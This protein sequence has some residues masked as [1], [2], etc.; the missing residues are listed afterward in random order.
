MHLPY[1]LLYCWL[2]LLV[3]TG[4][5]GPAAGQPQPAPTTT[6]YSCTPC[7]ALCDTLRQVGPGTCRY[8][9]MPLVARLKDARK[10]KPQHL[11]RRSLRGIMPPGRFTR[12]IRYQVDTLLQAA[13]GSGPVPGYAVGIF[14]QGEIVFAKG[15]G[16]AN[17]D[18]GVPNTPATVFNIASLSQ[19]VHR[20]LRSLTGATRALILGLVVV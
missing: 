4:A 5:A 6:V 10:Q 9:Q 18:H 19:A 1:P 16:L 15:Y 20:C 13:V 14:R 7:N 3:S 17:L 11:N 8:C 12:R 2:V